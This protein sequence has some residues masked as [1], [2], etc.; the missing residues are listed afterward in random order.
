MAN[1]KVKDADASDKYK[2]ASGAGSDVDPFIEECEVV[3]DTHDDLN[4]N[5]NMQVGNTDVGAGNPVPVD[6]TS[7]GDVPVT[8]DGETVEVVQDTHDDLNANA[9][10]QVGNTDVGAGNPVPIKVAPPTSGGYDV[11][12]TIDLDESEEEIKSS[13]GQVYGW[14]FSNESESDVY[15]KFYNAASASVTV[16]TTTPF[17]TVPLGAGKQANVEFAGG[18]EFDTG[19]CVAATTGVADNDTGA[20]SANDVVANVF[21]K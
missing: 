16:G 3:Q 18:I 4:A 19:I 9:N 21:Y 2:K 17:L 15:I 6:A 12:R 10:M 5:A 8:L 20:P 13:A 1:I 14:F 7:Q 11:H